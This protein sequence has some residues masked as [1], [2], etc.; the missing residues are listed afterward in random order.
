MVEHCL[1]ASSHLVA[2]GEG[3]E[4]MVQAELDQPR[5]SAASAMGAAIKAHAF[6][7]CARY[8]GREISRIGLPD[9]V[10]AA[11]LADVDPLPEAP[12]VVEVEAGDADSGADGHAHCPWRSWPC[13]LAVSGAACGTRAVPARKETSP[14]AGMRTRTSAHLRGSASARCA[15][16]PVRNWT[17]HGTRKRTRTSAHLPAS[18]SAR[19]ADLPV[20]N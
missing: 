5:F 12:G 6:E 3:V 10:D 7:L 4:R 8:Y 13:S 18:A 20:R 17:M 14:A 2:N 19:C 1:P 9:R 11:G 16:L 15:D